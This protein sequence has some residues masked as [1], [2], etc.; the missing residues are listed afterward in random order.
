MG[1]DNKQFV[2]SS[3]YKKAITI[4]F[5]FLLIVSGMFITTLTVGAGVVG[6]RG[7]RQGD[8]NNTTND[9]A[10]A[11]MIVEPNATSTY[12]VSM[13]NDGSEY[14]IIIVNVTDEDNVTTNGSAIASVMINL[15]GFYVGTNPLGWEDMVDDGSIPEDTAGDGNWTYNLSIQ[16]NHPVGSFWVDINATDN[17][18]TGFEMWTNTLEDMLQNITI[19][20]NQYNRNM[21]IASAGPI[22]MVEDGPDAY[23]ELNDTVFIDPDLADGNISDSLMFMVWDGDSWE[24]SYDGS[25]FTVDI[26]AGE[27]G[28]VTFSVKPDMYT[29]TAGEDVEFKA[30]DMEGHWRTQTINVKVAAMNDM[31]SWIWIDPTG[32]PEPD[33]VDV[34]EDMP[35]NITLE[36]DDPDMGDT[37]TYE[38]T[39]YYEMD[40]MGYTIAVEHDTID[41]IEVGNNQVNLT[42]DMGDTE[43]FMSTAYAFYLNISVSDGTDTANTTTDILVSG[44][45][46]LPELYY[47]ADHLPELD[48]DLIA[49]EDEMYNLT[50]LTVDN[51]TMDYFEYDFDILMYPEH[52]ATSTYVEAKINYT[53]YGMPM[54]IMIYEEFGIPFPFT[55]LDDYDDYTILGMSQFLFTPDN[56]DVGYMHLNFS[57][58]DGTAMDW[59]IVNITI[60]NVNDAPMFTKA[61]GAAV[62]TGDVLDYTGT[63]N[64]TADEEY[65]NITIEAEDVDLMHGGET[66][67]FDGDADLVS[68]GI[69]TITPWGETKANLSFM[70]PETKEGLNTVN[71]TVSDGDATDWFHMDIEVW[72]KPEGPVI[73][74]N[75]PPTIS[76]VS[77]GPKDSTTGIMYINE[78]I[79]FNASATDPDT[80]DVL[81]YKW[82]FG[83]GTDTGWM[84]SAYTTHQYL[85]AGTYNV[86]L[87]VKDSQDEE[88]TDTTQ[89]EIE[90]KEDTTT[91][92]DD[93]DDE[94]PLSM[95]L[96]AYDI[97]IIIIII[98]VII[99][100]VV[101]IAKK[102][103]PEEEEAMAPPPT[104]MTCTSCG[105][106]IPAGEAACPSCGAM[107]PAE[108]P[109]AETTCT[110]CGAFIPA[111]SASCPSCGAMAPAEAPP[112]E[113]TCT[114]CGAFIP[115]GSASC[116]SCGAMAPAEVP[117]EVVTCVT[118]GQV[119]PPG[120]PSCPACGAPAPPMTAPPEEEM[121]PMGPPPGEEAPMYEGAMQQDTGMPPAAPP[122]EQAPAPQEP[123]GAPPAQTVPCPQCQQP[124]GVGQTPCPSCG[125]QLNWG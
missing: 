48:L 35:M 5:G 41:V 16:Q 116:P 43:V 56:D 44:V 71:I 94:E 61:A 6:T 121:P 112:A 119:I 117:P 92:D 82:D 52:A 66:L 81:Q 93:D 45:N 15:T 50:F 28:N 109:P 21:T 25:V 99:I 68:S 84:N 88:D 73:P 74:E 30:V 90:E 106:V 51:D 2:K 9:F 122:P 17:G 20:I 10:P 60:E 3:R 18:T 24:T 125:A 12:T 89:L 83:D 11:I 1:L 31:P 8:M 107:A 123:A 57:V 102:K 115:A 79:E 63:M 13:L 46:D 23:L 103:K 78:D 96:F 64:L 39:L 111:G 69:L 114:S 65:L 19:N 59:M 98:V 67:T 75:N 118:C 33:Y 53:E 105:A 113:T 87:T 77:I 120:S 101:M 62:S 110:S 27:A 108:A 49:T 37:F 14:F 54:P 4:L 80:D 36:V 97:L 70:F 104:E 7:A 124:I 91:D 55:G 72:K 42:L 26:A 95:G 86:T 29:T 34:T 76:T 32:T 85:T 47:L 22:N 38:A 40:Y 100:V 58:D